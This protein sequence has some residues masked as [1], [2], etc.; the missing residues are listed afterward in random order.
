MRTALLILALATAALAQVVDRVAVVV[1]KTVITESEVAQ[2]AR[3]EEFLNQAPLD[4]GPAARKQ[5][6]ERL[7]DQQL[8]R[9]E[10]KVGA[11]TEPKPDEVETMLRNF[12]QERFPGDEEFHAALAKYGITED[13]LKQHLGW[14]LSAIRF[15]DSR[16]G[17]APGATATEANR[18]K[19][20]GTI[21]EPADIDKQFDAW[22]K[23]ARSETKVQFKQGAFQ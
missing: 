14:Q 5:A 19:T 18:V 3:I 7:V 4:L 10:M 8:V 13:Q 12:R 2:E 23:Q 20:D 15:T 11:Y 16:F 17:K 21:P 1:G 22:L 6:A 9:N